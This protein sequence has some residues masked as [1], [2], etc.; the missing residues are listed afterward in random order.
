MKIYIPTFY[1]DINLLKTQINLFKQNCTKDQLANITYVINEYSLTKINAIRSVIEQ[2]NI[3]YIL[4][5]NLI[6]ISWFKDVH[7][8]TRQ[9]II[10][11]CCGDGRYVVLDTKNFLIKPIT[12][13]NSSICSV[14]S[15]L[16]P[17]LQ[18]WPFFDF[19]Q[20]SVNKYM[21]VNSLRPIICPYLID[22]KITQQIFQDFGGFTQFV[23]WFISFKCPSEFIIYD[24]ADQMYNKKSKYGT[25]HIVNLVLWNIH[26]IQKIY[27]PSKGLR[28]LSLHRNAYDECIKNS[29]V[30]RLLQVK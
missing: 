5:A 6:S 15:N 16:A 11:L 26:D 17:V 25:K 7:G 30:R 12:I 2:H 21:S 9:Q 10:K 27:E 24:I 23:E 28:F 29:D 14:R 8:W 20:S 3:K 22:S 13:F 1:G 18:D 19:Y 4:V